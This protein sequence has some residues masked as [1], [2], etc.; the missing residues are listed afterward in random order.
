MADGGGINVKT[1]KTT[2]RARVP[3]RRPATP[4]RTYQPKSQAAI[5]Q[6]ALKVGPANDPLE[7]EAEATSER[8]VSMGTPSMEAPGAPDT[9]PA[10]PAAQR[11][12]QEDQ[13]NTDTFET[14]PDIPAD[15]QDPDVP[16][17]ED[18]DT[19]SLNQDEFSEIEDGQPDDPAGD[20]IAPDRNDS[21]AAVVGPEGGTAPR[22]V[23][24]AVAQPGAG[25]PLPQS[26]RSFMEPRFG[27]DFSDVRIH[28]TASDRKT[29]ARIGARAFTH[30]GD[31]WMGEG[32]TVENRRLMAHELT[33]VVQQTERQPVGKRGVMRAD[34]EEEAI[35]PEVQ[36]GWAANKAEKYARNVPGYTLLTVILG[37]S[38]I[39]GNKVSRNAENLVGGFLGLIP[40]GEQIFQRL[41]ET[42]ALQKAFDW[43]STRLA[44]LNIT[45][46][47]IKGLVSDFIDEMPDWSPIEEAK[48]IFRPLVQDIITFVGDIKDKIL[49][50]IVKGALALAGPYGERVWAVIEKARDTISMILADPLGFAKNLVGAV[51]KGF[52]QFGSRIWEHLKKGLMGWLFGAM[53]G[54]GIEMPAKLDFKGVI[55][56][57]L[58][59]L[60]LTY[61][62]FRAMLVKRLGANGEKKVAFLEKSVEVVK[63]LLKEGFL[64]VWQRF[65]Q[66]IEGFKETVIGGIQ[67][68]VVE[69]IVMGAISW[70]AGLSNPVGAVVKVA[71]AIYNMIKA[72]LE[73]IDQIVELAN[74]IFSSIGA[75]AKGQV[76]QAADFIE[77]TIAATIPVVLAFVAALIPVTGITRTIKTIIK[78][79]QAPVEKALKKMIGFLVKK[80]KKLFSKVL[81]KINK[82]RKL[83]GY[84]FKIGKEDHSVYAQKKGGKFQV[85][86][87]SKNPMRSNEV[88]KQLAD[89][90]EVAKQAGDDSKCTDLFEEAF[91][92]ELDEAEIETSRVKPDQQ[93][94]STAKPAQ[95]A[96]DQLKDAGQKLAKLGPCL[97]NNIFIDTAPDD[98][99]IIRAREPRL[100]EVE[101]NTGK[102][103]D[104]GKVTKLKIDEVVTSA[105]MGP[106]GAQRISSFYENDHI[107]EKSLAGRVK[108]FVEG[109]LKGNATPGMREGG[110]AEE[111]GGPLLGEIETTAVGTKGS[112]LPAMTVY[113]PSHRQK[114]GEDAGSRDHGA[115]IE[116]A[117]TGKTKREKISLLR[118]GI[119]TE[120]QKEVDHVT[121]AYAADTAATKHI[122]G[123]VK[124][125][126]KTMGRENQRL[127]GVGLGKKVKLDTKKQ[128]AA[129]SDLPLEGDTS[130]K[131]PNF[132]QLEGGHAIH[133]K[134]PKNV[135]NYLEY[136]HLVEATL[137]EK[138]RDL[139]LG[140]PKLLEL[141]S[142]KVVPKLAE[143]EDKGPVARRR[144]SKARRKLRKLKKIQ[145][146][147][148]KPV[149]SYS[150]GN[151]GTIALYRPVHREVSIVRNKALPDDLMAG[152][153]LQSA[154]DDLASYAVRFDKD[155]A[156]RD[157]GV[158]EVRTQIHGLLSTEFDDH[159]NLIKTHYK[160]EMA[161]FIAVNKGNKA[162]VDQMTMIVSKVGTT[163]RKL[164]GDS[165]SQL[166]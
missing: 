108:E 59:I 38:P 21:P 126:L 145:V 6:P 52:K 160:T 159:A 150:R 12:S 7:R 119:Q 113:R 15:H 32:E 90:A 123:K 69:T 118:Q 54:A 65:L 10:P 84:G 137:A 125:G 11:A 148:R 74:S 128:G 146:F 79:L 61:A 71:L 40:G 114:T 26:V 152:V 45:W 63:I 72:F 155:P 22:D 50:F 144:E 34:L 27:V 78:K 135:G 106:R 96:G 140:H 147:K 91:Q 3:V 99:K 111:D 35:E 87:A 95:K 138:A 154:A 30:R 47:R 19:A 58:Q 163:L 107:P 101:G 105:K 117:R 8:I 60:G 97:E 142:S 130:K 36:R 164:R 166:Q 51:V 149:A 48:R 1:S 25:R 62:K 129:G 102:H 98:G 136:D 110:G 37:R 16:K 83:P 44:E 49:E 115:I 5:L 109:E 161:D 131:I 9:P 24:R 112:Q 39:T 162:A 120:L 134:K 29:A 132:S 53:Q 116:R 124:R 82:K 33:H 76:K 70:V 28:D 18:V 13:P 88:Q 153:N 57:G 73:R 133:G 67:K 4:V 46:S 157:A 66:M 64:G 156:F 92:R 20:I 122:L 68:F 43:V 127:Y 31:I 42:K 139:T 143:F 85:M 23:T 89:E 14:A 86:V 17:T 2:A 93:R 56:I 104:L 100:P 165:L 151:A 77:K 75:I 94:A 80:A 158:Q 55:S 121:E 103:L 81:G 41:K 141:A